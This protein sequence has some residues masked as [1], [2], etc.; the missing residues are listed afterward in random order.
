M[1]EETPAEQ[2]SPDGQ[3]GNEDLT[4]DLVS[5]A[6]TTNSS[7]ERL[8]EALQD[9]EYEAIDSKTLAQA[10]VSASDQGLFD[11]TDNTL[12]DL[13]SRR[14]SGF[15]Y[16]HN[17]SYT[18]LLDRT[19]IDLIRNQQI[20][21][22]GSLMSSSN[23]EISTFERVVGYMAVDENE[24]QKLMQQI[25]SLH[26]EKQAKLVSQLQKNDFDNAT[27]EWLL[28][29]AVDPDSSLG[30]SHKQIQRIATDY[31]LGK[32]AAESG[33]SLLKIATTFETIENA[34]LANYTDIVL[35]KLI[36]LNDQEA[37]QAYLTNLRKAL[38]TVREQHNTDESQVDLR[39]VA[40]SL[41][42]FSNP[43]A[44]LRLAE[45]I[46]QDGYL[47]KLHP[48]TRLFGNKPYHELISFRPEDTD[49]I[50]LLNNYIQES[51][52]DADLS[53]FT[54]IT[55]KSEMPL[56]RAQAMIE[57][58]KI[59]Q[60]GKDKS[61]IV[62][63]EIRNRAD[64]LPFCRAVQ[65]FDMHFS[66]ISAETHRDLL[67]RIIRAQNPEATSI[68]L[69]KANEQLRN[70]GFHI[71]DL[72]ERSLTEALQIAETDTDGK[73]IERFSSNWII[74]HECEQAYNKYLQPYRE[75][76][77]S[78][79]T[80]P[81][82]KPKL[83]NLPEVSSRFEKIGIEPELAE[84]MLE[85]WLTY[86]ALGRRLDHDGT[87]KSEI[88]DKDIDGSLV[89]YGDRLI[90]HLDALS[91]YVEQ[92]GIE[93][94]KT[95]IDTFGIYNFIRYS[96]DQLHN[97][98]L[99]W[100]SGEIPA[101]N[102]V[103]SARAD[104]N[105]AIS[106]TGNEFR[107]VFG[108]E[109]FY[110]FEANDRGM[111]AKIAVAI[112]DRERAAGRNPESINALENFVIHTHASPEGLLLGTKD[113]GLTVEDYKAEPFNGRSANTYKRHL[114]DRFRVI[115]KG[116]STAS[117]AISGKNIAESISDHHDIRVEGSK[118]ITSGSIII[119][120]DGTVKFNQGNLPA[121]VYDD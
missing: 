113:E 94:T 14:K 98:L 105:G 34:G 82:Q 110:C 65:Y 30:A 28:N 26:Q 97:Q 45:N 12:Q 15:D 79:L 73:K 38:D 67:V 10:L 102:I 56:E 109:G 78:R 100:Q 116:C 39:H 120:P 24:S 66:E 62:L 55:V 121:T 27:I 37:S 118:M 69:A 19:I 29:G 4:T 44:A 90:T 68:L 76:G 93:E 92:F 5:I 60:D 95:L 13:R 6:E 101:R 99:S 71:Q 114:G 32:I 58:M 75:S 64:P 81:E 86:S 17:D 77:D 91:D 21:L 41:S 54:S 103:I 22:A 89:E 85:S 52:I 115:L 35:Q 53:D 48:L 61:G 88:T 33:E 111:L 9:A 70:Q 74:Q 107:Q 63:S 50:V 87:V 51:G 18:G 3:M 106:E 40:Q 31:T 57:G 104:W 20:D 46:Y 49:S 72:D 80:N 117:E 59:T 47:E 43:V 112:G 23:T 1:E 11:E 8:Q 16:R 2:H 119:E 96:P 42:K 36:K 84:S 25:H 7:R 108:D 83:A